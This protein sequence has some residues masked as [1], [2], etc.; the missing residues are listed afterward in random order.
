M[1]YTRRADCIAIR[2]SRFLLGKFDVT[3]CKYFKQNSKVLKKYADKVNVRQ[4]KSRLRNIHLERKK[5]Y[6][7]EDYNPNK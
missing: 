7:E 1:F 2:P 6:V 4:N 5:G 3:I